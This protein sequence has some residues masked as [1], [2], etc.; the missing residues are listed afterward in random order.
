MSRPLNQRLSSSVHPRLG[1]VGATCDALVR[2]EKLKFIQ[3]DFLLLL[4]I[5]L[6]GRPIERYCR[7]QCFS[8]SKF[9]YCAFNKTK[10]ILTDMGGCLSLSF[11][12]HQQGEQIPQAKMLVLVAAIQTPCL[13]FTHT[14]TTA[15]VICP[16]SHS[17]LVATHMVGV[18]QIS[19]QLSHGSGSF[20]NQLWMQQHCMWN[21]VR[22][23]S[24]KVS[25]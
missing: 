12:L 2:F 15:A 13:C 24:Y 19:Y 21:W 4:S 20:P 1:G 16:V 9:A 17:L 5:I 11:F 14:G 18:H 3:L 23:P 8:D 7:T 25:W 10:N 22:Q 6:A